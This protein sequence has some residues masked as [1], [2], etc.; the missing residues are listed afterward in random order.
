MF[1]SVRFPL[2]FAIAC[3]LVLSALPAQAAPDAR[4]HDLAQQEK[5]P[6]LDTL[7]DLVNIE[8]GSKDTEGL[9]R[10]A[11][12][13]AE[14]LTGLGGKVEIIEPSEVYR[15]EDTPPKPGSMVHAEF[16]GTGA[17]KIMLIAHMD[18]VYL[19]GMLKDQPF[20][21]DG[22]RAY[23]LGI[24]DDK[25]GV[26]LILHAVAMLQKLK[27]TDYG[28]LTV[29]I[30]GDEE[31]SSPGARATITRMAGEQDAVF[32]YEGG[33]MDGNLRLATSGIG[34]AYLTVD[35]KASHAGSA[36]DRGVNALV[37][38]SHQILQLSDLSRKEQGLSLNW[39][40][41]Q[42]GTNRN[43]IPAQATAQA[44]ARALQMSDFAGLEATLQE[45]VKTQRIPDAKV[46]L[47]FEMRR[48]PLQ[49]T[50]ASRRLSAN[51]AA[52]YQE[53]GLPLKVLDIATGGGTDAA[54]AALKT[55]AAVIEGFG[56]SGF[57]AH[58]NDAE[59]VRLESIVPR[60]YLSVRMI[61]DV[62]QDKVK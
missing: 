38:L 52:V 14:R 1:R 16:K 33:G 9:A 42:A 12:L 60:L 62:A 5:A 56:L 27:F 46:A 17:K 61:M 21:I 31:I 39:T 15:M 44:D 4:I 23:G 51:G 53:L 11:A 29:L 7:R 2:H 8:S 34:S 55:S 18:T 22:D 47:R 30:N 45:R 32:S 59:Y 48:P 36:P 24:A 6:L 40:V 26:A 41:S 54:F 35:G 19:R 3:T 58:S 49:A 20:R 28:T 43:V 25:Q 57:G 10:L 13:I 37:E 50:P